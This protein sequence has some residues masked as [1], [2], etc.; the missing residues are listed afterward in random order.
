M[1]NDAPSG[2]PYRTAVRAATDTASWVR[3]GGLLGCLAL[4]GCAPGGP[5]ASVGL[6]FRLRLA[7]FAQA[8]NAF[9]D[10]AGSGFGTLKLL[11]LGHARQAVPDGHQA[12]RRPAGHQCG[13]FLL[14][15][16]AVAGDG[17]G[18]DLFGA[19]KRCNVV[20]FVNGESRHG[21]F[22]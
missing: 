13:E 17:A 19:G 16:E 9:P 2:R 21:W 8:L 4:G 11:Y 7:G 10:A 15:A 1:L 20:L 3:H 12:F 22:S 14:A 18:R 6:T 5:C